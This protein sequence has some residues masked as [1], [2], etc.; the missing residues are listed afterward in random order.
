MDDD[1]M[2]K[3]FNQMNQK[4]DSLSQS[5]ESLKSEVSSIKTRL[6]NGITDTTRETYSRVIGLETKQGYQQDVLENLQQKWSERF[7]VHDTKERLYHTVLATVM[8]FLV[9]IFVALVIFEL[10]KYHILKLL[11][12]EVSPVPEKTLPRGDAGKPAVPM[13]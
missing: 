1:L 8:A 11:A 13:P 4:I 5:T 6:F 10:E 12:N 3:L 9:T 2:I 7:S